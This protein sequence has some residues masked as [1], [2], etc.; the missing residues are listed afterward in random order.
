MAAVPFPLMMR[1]H[2]EKICRALISDPLRKSEKHSVIKVPHS[3]AVRWTWGKR[4][5]FNLKWSIKVVFFI[6]RVSTWRDSL[7]LRHILMCTSAL[8]GYKMQ[9]GYSVDQEW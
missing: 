5:I 4:Q 7:L 1:F 9:L 8:S 6:F 3:R 2:R